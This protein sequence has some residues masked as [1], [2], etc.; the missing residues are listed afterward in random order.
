MKDEQGQ[1]LLRVHYG[2]G[3]KTAWGPVEWM[4]WGGR[5]FRMLVPPKAPKPVAIGFWWILPYYW[6]KQ[7]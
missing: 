7:D 6:V 4:G 1:S 2:D 5:R 3:E